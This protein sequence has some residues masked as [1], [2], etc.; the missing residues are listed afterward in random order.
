[1]LSQYNFK[2]MQAADFIQLDKCEMSTQRNEMRKNH[3]ALLTIK[4]RNNEQ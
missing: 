1:M 3:T 2:S 4:T